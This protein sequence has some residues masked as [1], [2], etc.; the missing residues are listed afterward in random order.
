MSGPGDD[1]FRNNLPLSR[2]AR[3]VP[4]LRHIDIDLVQWCRRCREPEVYIEATSAAEKNTQVTRILASHAGAPTILL[5]HAYDDRELEHPVHIYLWE[6]GRV[7]RH[8]EPDQEIV[9][10]T[11]KKF[12]EVLLWLHRKHECE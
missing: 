6:P 2:A 4:G 11:W 3:R 1:G 12:Q 8:D 5:R 10:T 7:E 9:N